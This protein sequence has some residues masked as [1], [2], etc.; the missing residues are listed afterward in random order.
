M[1]MYARL[2]VSLALAGAPALL[3]A[4]DAPP[5]PADLTA[6]RC[7]GC[8]EW[9]EPQRPFRIH[10][11]AWYVGTRGLSAILVT[12]PEGHVLLDGALPESAPL[13]AASIRALGFRLED[14]KLILNSHAHF[15]HAGGIAALQRASGA[16]VA[17]HPWSA[18]VLRQG[19]SLPDDPQYGVLVPYPPVPANGAV[20]TIADGETVRV[21]PLAL[22]AHF[23]G[24]HTPGGT[25]WSWRS[26]EG[27]RCWDF[28]YADSQTPI[29]DDDFLFT[30]STRYPSAVADFERGHAALER[31]P[32]DVLL[33]PHP[34]FSEVFERLVKREAGDAEAF[35][36]PSGC[37]DYAAWARQRLAE[38]LAK[39]RG[40]GL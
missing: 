39:E 38:R 11:N 31:L 34:G 15:D 10:G 30:R 20:R 24:G 14:V 5:A 8:A 4:Q 7:D 35:R 9:N 27:E 22:T 37:R 17:V 19:R 3:H 23:T 16:T 40:A 33:A 6:I 2:L 13:I 1:P 12:S 29:S 26:C 25:S 18:A 21:G 28:V 36:N 32:C